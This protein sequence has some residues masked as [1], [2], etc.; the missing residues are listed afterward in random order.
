[1]SSSF[2]I[3][4]YS[5]DLALI[6]INKSCWQLLFS[7]GPNFTN[8]TVELWNDCLMARD[9]MMSRTSFDARI[10]NDTREINLKLDDFYGKSLGYLKII[11]AAF[12][13]P[14]YL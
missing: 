5:P 13:D 2:S 8:F 11:V 7:R 1:M 14:M 4:D 6:A 10:D 12:D 9:H 3:G